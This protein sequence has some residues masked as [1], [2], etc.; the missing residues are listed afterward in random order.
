MEL[1]N[2]LIVDPTDSEHENKFKKFIE[3]DRIIN[4]IVLGDDDNAKSLVEEADLQA[5]GHSGKIERRVAWI[6]DH[7]TLRDLSLEY[8][9][10]M[11]E[12]NGEYDQTLGYTLSPKFHECKYV[13]MNGDPIADFNVSKA[14]WFASLRERSGPA[15]Q[16]A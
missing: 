11:P 4:F 5:D 8:L 13:F 7:Q 12:Y 1:L 15:D 6:K 14:Y 16:P 10:T 2:T 3:D 9:K